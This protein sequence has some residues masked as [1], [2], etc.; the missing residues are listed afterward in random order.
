M[1]YKATQKTHWKNQITDCIRYF[2]D[3]QNN[4]IQF[5]NDY[6]TIQL[7]CYLVNLK[8]LNHKGLCIAKINPFNANLY[9]TN[10]GL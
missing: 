1:R 8:I 3:N 4:S 7:I 5:A 6:N 10:K 2:L 9:L